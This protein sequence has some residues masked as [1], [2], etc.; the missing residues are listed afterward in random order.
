MTNDLSV[1]K[2][3]RKGCDEITHMNVYLIPYD[4]E[5]Y[6]FPMATAAKNLYNLC[7]IRMSTRKTKFVEKFWCFLICRLSFR[8]VKTSQKHLNGFWRPT[9]YFKYRQALLSKL[10][11][12]P[13]FINCIKRIKSQRCCY[14]SSCIQRLL[15]S[16]LYR[17][18][19]IIYVNIHFLW[20]YP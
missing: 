17:Q 18:L 10:I 19:K 3:D 20:K 13:A 12:G 8:N 1:S 4:F 9:C 6:Y 11:C 14:S 2:L 16:L 15:L 7:L 5:F